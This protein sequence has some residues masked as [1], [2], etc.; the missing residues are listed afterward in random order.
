MTD[1]LYLNQIA[2]G[3]MKTGKQSKRDVFGLINLMVTD[4]D[5][6]LNDADKMKLYSFFMPPMPKKTKTAFDWVFQA[7]GTEETRP[8]L[9]FVYVTEDGSEMVATDGHRLH[10]APN[11]HDLEPGFYNSQRV[12][13]DYTD[14]PFPDWKRIVPEGGES[15]KWNRED[16]KILSRGDHTTNY[17]HVYNIFE[18]LHMNGIYFEQA[19]QGASEVEGEYN[20]D[21][22]PAKFYFEDGFYAVVM[23]IRT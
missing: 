12:K 23:P 10:H 9:H 17:R 11:V 8:Y 6:C 2:T 7:A 3:A 15:F 16:L 5:Y 14:Q 13:V 19:V 4:R 21:M 18:G 22:S 20:G 1:T